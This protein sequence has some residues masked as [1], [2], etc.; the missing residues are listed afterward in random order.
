MMSARAALHALKALLVMTSHSVGPSAQRCV[1]ELLDSSSPSS[2]SG[3][4]RM[5]EVLLTA[6][7][8][9]KQGR[10]ADDSSNDPLAVW[11]QLVNHAMALVVNM[12]RTEEGAVELVGRSLPDEAVA[13]SFVPP[14]P[15]ESGDDAQSEEQQQQQQLPRP[16]DKARLPNKPTIELLLARFLNVAQYADP[17]VNYRALLY[18][19]TGEGGGGGDPDSTDL[20]LSSQ[21]GDPFQ[22]FASVL[23]NVAQVES[24]RLF[25][26]K[27]RRNPTQ[28]DKAWRAP[29]GTAVLIPT[30]RGGS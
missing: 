27:I 5:M 21:S 30:L 13:S 1:D 18:D 7:P 4:N 3:M 6:P 26:L 2:A 17:R 19:P 9:Q 10:S 15:W 25:V 8:L 20:A 22:H 24:G 29:F 16:N 28:E 14:P 11:R 23:M 12:T